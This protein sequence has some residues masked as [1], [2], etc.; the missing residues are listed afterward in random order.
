MQLENLNPDYIF[1]DATKLLFLDVIM[2]NYLKIILI[3]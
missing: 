2:Y 3:F 1:K